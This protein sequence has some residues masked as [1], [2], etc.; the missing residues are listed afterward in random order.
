MESYS[1]NGEDLKILEYFKGRKG[2]LLSVGEN[3]GITFSNAKL[4]IDNG[5]AATLL[6][7]SSVF[8][9]LMALHID[10]PQIDCHKIGLS[11]ETG[12]V[13]F[14]ESEN[15]V[16]NGTDKA[17]VSSSDYFETK[18]WRN[19]GVKFQEK[20]IEVMSFSDF[21]EG[22]GRK[23]FNFIS[24]DCEGVDWIILQQ[25]NLS[26][27]ECE[28]LII[29][30]NGNKKLEMDYRI[31]VQNFGLKEIHRNAENIIYAR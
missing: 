30:W 1:Q 2:K 25:I 8:D 28:C 26:E 21:Y 15:H 24:I 12:T 7:P 3:D 11:K 9:D 23:K 19:A 27:V 4:L 10:N 6:E 13:K 17:L 16:P 22:I 20:T 14:W 18:R 5:W 29:E 31:Y